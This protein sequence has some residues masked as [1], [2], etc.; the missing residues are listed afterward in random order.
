ASGISAALAAR[1]AA[2][3]QRQIDLVADDRLA[4]AARVQLARHFIEQG[5]LQ[6]AETVLLLC[7]QSRHATISGQATRILAEIWSGQGLHHDAA[8][9]LVEL[10]TNFADVEVAPQQPGTAWLARL[11]R[12]GESWS[13]YQRLTRPQWS[14]SSAAIHEERV[15]NEILHTTYNG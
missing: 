15:T 2:G 3:A 12:D 14:G 1:D 13:A 10:A 4:D 6:K 7:R 11:P 9:M 5:Q 8:R